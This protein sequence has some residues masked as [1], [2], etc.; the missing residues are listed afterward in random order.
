[1]IALI[2]VRVSEAVDR[3]IEHGP[4]RL[5][6]IGRQ[7]SPAT[8]EPKPERSA[9][10]DTDIAADEHRRRLNSVIPGQHRNNPGLQDAYASGFSAA[11]YRQR[12]D[13]A[14]FLI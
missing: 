6:A 8:G 14:E 4:T 1:M 7:V 11:P 2:D 9:G 13:G 10:P 5:V 12:P 3:Y